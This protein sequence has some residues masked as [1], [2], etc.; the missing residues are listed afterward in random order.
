MNSVIRV[1]FASTR[2]SPPHERNNRV[3]ATEANILLDNWVKYKTCYDDS[4]GCARS[5]T[6]S[7]NRGAEAAAK[8]REFLEGMPAQNANVFLRLT[9]NWQ[10]PCRFII[11]FSIKFHPFTWAHF[12]TT[13][14]HPLE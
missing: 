9:T 4:V 1:G 2:R 13:A 6:S 3:A 8:E 12:H 10:F 7:V 5:L 14:E 11:K